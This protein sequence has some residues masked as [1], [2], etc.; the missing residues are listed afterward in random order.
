VLGPAVRMRE[1][2]PDGRVVRPPELVLAGGQHYSGVSLARQGDQQWLTWAELADAAGQR[3]QAYA[4]P[5][6]AAG[7]PGEA[8]RLTHVVSSVLWPCMGLDPDGGQ[9]VTWQQSA[10]AYVYRLMYI[11]NLDPARISA[12]QRL[13][14]AGDWGGWSL[15]MALAEGAV[16]AVPTVALN[17][18]RLAIGWA[19]AWLALWAAGHRAA[20][21]PYARVV[22]WGVLLVTLC[23]VVRPEAK[24]LGQVPI[25]IM[26]LVHWVMAVAASAI[27]LYL[28]RVWREGL[29]QP[30]IWAGLG[31]VW[32]G[33]YYWINLVLILRAGFAV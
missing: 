7:Q 3:F 24:T 22:A 6:D 23:A 18:W 27:A 5:L 20:A 29:D 25:Q 13:G 33:V 15:A 19:A 26:P 9:H 14:F 8:V 16:L 12:W 17:A 31:G 11:N 28:G 21:R 1:I 4:A 10:G 2:D 32:L 30:W